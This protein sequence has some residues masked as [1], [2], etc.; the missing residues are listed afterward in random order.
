M[1]KTRVRSAVTGRFKTKAFGNNNPRTTVFEK[2]KS[3]RS[4][5]KKK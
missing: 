2:V 5:P 3:P 1:A 4:K